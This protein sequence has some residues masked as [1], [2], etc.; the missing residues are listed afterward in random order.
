MLPSV[1]LLE[2]SSSSAQS[3]LRRVVE[4]HARCEL[5]AWQSFPRESLNCTQLQLIV[6]SVEPQS[7]DTA[8]DFLRWLLRNPVPIPVLAVL[9]ESIYPE[10]LQ[11]V[12]EV[13]DDFLF[14]PVREEEL[15][16]RL[17]RILAPRSCTEILEAET[18]LA[19][20]VGKDPSF[21]MALEQVKLFTGSNATVL[22]TGET[23]TGKE[24]F[25]HAIHSLGRRKNGPFIPIDCSALPEHLAES[26]LFGHCRGAFTDAHSDR[27]GLAA[28][29]EGGTLFLDEID[30]LSLASQAKILRLLQEGT[31]RS[32][33][34]DRFVRANVRVIAA[35]NLNMEECVRERR[36]RS[37]LYFRV[38]VLRLHLPSLRERRG[39]ITLLAKY[40]LDRQTVEA[41][42]PRKAFSPAALRRLQSYSWPGNVRELFNTVERAAVCCVGRQITSAHI[43]FV[44]YSIDSPN[45]SLDCSFRRA[46]QFMIERFEQDYIKGLMAKHQGNITHAAQEACKERR[47]FGKL[48][49]KYGIMPSRTA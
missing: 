42:G 2:G 41:N 12:A 18:G 6:A 36:F 38:N 14:W 23:G 33:G 37:D 46:K 27:K 15:N 49:K 11:T 7:A 22:I 4:L 35:S 17:A 16:I 28:M 24:L 30:S 48:V 45:N 5:R 29:A 20:L 44:G 40:F 26:E 13:T 9:P 1:L 31:Y 25:A 10:L 8:A 34:S 32:L 21:V 19:N 43:S 47:A 3:E 39:D